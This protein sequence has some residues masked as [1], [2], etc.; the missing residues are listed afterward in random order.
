[1]ILTTSNILHNDHSLLFTHAQQIKTLIGSTEWIHCGAINIKLNIF[2]S[3][4]L[5]IKLHRDTYSM[6]L[7][8]QQVVMPCFRCFIFHKFLAGKILTPNSPSLPHP[9]TDISVCWQMVIISTQIN[10]I[11]ST[12]YK[13]F[14]LPNPSFIRHGSGYC[15]VNWFTGYPLALCER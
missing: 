13:Y 9:C 11:Q 6:A 7:V 5:Y 2:R 14:T 8:W 3:C 15:N 4:E 12:L 10:V 1:M